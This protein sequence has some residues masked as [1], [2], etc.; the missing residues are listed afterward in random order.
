MLIYLAASPRQSVNA[1][2]RNGSISPRF[3]ALGRHGCAL[4]SRYPA[5]ILLRMLY[6]LKSAFRAVGRMPCRRHSAGASDATAVCP[7]RSV[8]LI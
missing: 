3:T 4:P 6:F 8:A 2:L 1:K 7:T 5:H